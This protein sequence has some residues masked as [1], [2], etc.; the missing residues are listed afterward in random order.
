MSY[1]SHVCDLARDVLRILALTLD[2]PESY[3]NQFTEDAVATMR[4]LHYPPQPKDDDEKLSRGIGAHTD[5]GALTLLLQEEVDGLQVWEEKTK[6]WLD[7]GLYPQ[8]AL[9]RRGA[10][11]HRLSQP[12]GPMLLTWET[13]S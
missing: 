7:V 12:R 2:L 10:D 4:L 1:Y 13:S 11:N 5:F 6:T 9:W 8:S 3:F